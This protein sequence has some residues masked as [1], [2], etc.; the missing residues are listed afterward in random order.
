MSD[1]Y[2]EIDDT[3]LENAGEEIEVVEEKKTR[4]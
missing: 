3:E 2:K 1:N 4:P